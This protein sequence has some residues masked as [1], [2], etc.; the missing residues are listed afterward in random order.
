[1][2]VIIVKTPKEVGVT[3]ANIIADHILRKPSIVLGL[4]TGSSPLVVYEE[5]VRKHKEGGLDFSKV[6]TFNL[7]EYL[8]LPPTHPQSYHYFMYTNLFRH[9]NINMAN[10]H[11]PSG[12]ALDPHDFCRSYE[13]DIKRAGG[14]DLQLLGIGRDGHIA[15]NEPGSSLGSRTRVKTLT[16]ETI[17]DNAR[18]FNNADEV[19]RFAI[20]MGVGTI[21]EARKILLIATGRNKAQAIAEAV[22]GPITAMNTASVLQLHPDCTFILDEE[23]ASLLKRKDYYNWIQ[24]NKHQVNEVI[25]RQIRSKLQM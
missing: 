23:A 25:T 20:T 19:P 3:T 12:L 24:K 18:F 8:G 21:M 4:P 1:M 11:V 13:E 17:E 9:I 2:E 16:K 6:T 15:F 14:I 5:L 7:D 10:V 22:E